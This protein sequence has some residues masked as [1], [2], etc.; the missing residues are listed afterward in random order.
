[1]QISLPE[2]NREKNL[3]FDDGARREAATLRDDSSL[4]S[5]LQLSKRLFPRKGVCN[6]IL[7]LNRVF[8]H[9]LCNRRK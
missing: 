3:H 9:L 4:L 8:C 6:Q 2:K 5:K 1:M 7:F